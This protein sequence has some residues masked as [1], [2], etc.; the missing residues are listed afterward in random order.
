[1]P[2]LKQLD[3]TRVMPPENPMRFSMDDEKMQALMDSMRN[4]GLL[5]P[6]GV[7]DRG[8]TFTVEFGHR[9]YIAATRLEWRTI[10][11]MVYSENEIAEGAAML[12]ENVEREEVT[13]AE[14]AIMFAE[15]QERFGL[16]EAGLCARFK[17]SPYYIG[18]RLELLRKD[19]MVFKALQERRINFSVARELNRFKKE[20][21]RRYYLDAIMRN[22]GNARLVASWRQQHEAMPQPDAAGVPAPEPVTQD[23]SSPPNPIACVLC[24]GHKDPWNLVSVYIHKY[25]LDQIQKLI[26]ESAEV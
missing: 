21:D 8:E 13:A 26:K 1:M 25:E 9:R 17:K 5:Q 12:A 15:A 3:I 11:A 20:E 19:E 7:V 22:G 6:I 18:E 10:A 14:E 2:V 4:L 16:D 24:G 23:T